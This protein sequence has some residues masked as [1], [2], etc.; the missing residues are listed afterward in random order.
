M[1][2]RKSVRANVNK[3]PTEQFE[4]ELDFIPIGFTLEAHIRRCA[5]GFSR[6]GARRIFIF[7]TMTMRSSINGH[8]DGDDDDDDVIV[9]QDAFRP[10]PAKT[11]LIASGD[12]SPTNSGTSGRRTTYSK[13]VVPTAANQPSDAKTRQVK[14][15]ADES[16][17]VRVRMHT[18]ES[19]NID[20][21]DVYSTLKQSLVHLE[22]CHVCQQPH[23]L[24]PTG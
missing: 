13:S 9:V 24:S 6:G 19:A 23:R 18:A 15:A 12:D 14:V 8:D 4:H 5:R 2:C 17:G 10:S 16:D 1:A 11:L 22:Q 21:I 7:R 20:R 3:V